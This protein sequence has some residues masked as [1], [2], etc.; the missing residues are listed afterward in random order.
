MSETG[1]GL[2]H[3]RQEEAALKALRQNGGWMSA[4]QVARAYGLPNGYRTAWTMRRLRDSG[5]VECLT[6]GNVN[7]YRIPPRSSR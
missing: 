3:L 6:A 5:H 2:R 7:L 1:D 4:A